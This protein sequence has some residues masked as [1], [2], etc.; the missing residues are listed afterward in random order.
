MTG[1]GRTAGEGD[2][3]SGEREKQFTE[4]KSGPTNCLLT[5]KGSWTFTTR[6]GK[7]VL[8][9]FEGPSSGILATPGPG[10]GTKKHLG[11]KK[12]ALEFPAVRGL[13]ALKGKLEQGRETWLSEMN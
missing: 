7:I 6:H 13:R 9:F 10:W 11:K 3:G 4:V 12:A 5:P 2:K 1:I 8:A